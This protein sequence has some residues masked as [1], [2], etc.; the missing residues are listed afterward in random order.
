[1]RRCAQSSLEYILM[2]SLAFIIVAFIIIQLIG[3][4]GYAKKAGETISAVNSRISSELSTIQ[5]NG[6]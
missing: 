1:M 5:E 6:T 3:V 2:F 4:K